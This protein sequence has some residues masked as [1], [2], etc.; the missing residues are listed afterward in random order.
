MMQ[1]LKTRH[2]TNILGAP[3]GWDPATQGECIGLPAHWDAASHRWLSWHHPTEQDIANILAGMPIRLS[4]FGGGHPPVA[5][6][7]TAGVEP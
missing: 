6:A 3:Q 5:I 4:V 7:V 1:P 2:T